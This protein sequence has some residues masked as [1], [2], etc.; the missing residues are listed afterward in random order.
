MA[1]LLFS[2][3]FPFKAMNF[4]NDY[5]KIAHI[6]EVIVVIVLGVFPGIIVLSTSSYQIDRFPPDT[7]FPSVDLLFHTLA[8]PIAVCST[9]GLAMLFTEFIILRT[10]SAMLSIATS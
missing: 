3:A 5:S 7:C 4:M 1:H 6:T 9:A 10:V 8:L 2:L